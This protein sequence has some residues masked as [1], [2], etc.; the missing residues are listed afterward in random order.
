[1]TPPAATMDEYRRQI[2]QCARAL[3][4][5]HNEKVGSYLAGGFTLDH[6]KLF[7]DGNLD[8][9]YQKLLDQVE[10]LNDA[11]ENF[12]ELVVEYVKTLPL[13]AY[14]TGCSDG[15]RFLRWIGESQNP[16]AEQ[17][18]Y[19]ACQR[20][21]HVVET[22]GRSKRLSH[23]R[24]QEIWSLSSQL[25]GELDANPKL[26]VHLNPIRTWSTFQTSILLDEEASLPATVLFCACGDQIRT[27]VL[28]ISGQTLVSELETIGPCTLAE[29]ARFSAVYQRDGL[30]EFCRESAEIGLIAFG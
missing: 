13:A 18:D 26:R 14:D 30:V 9:R 21:R 5:A 8:K 11:F 2:Q 16:T 27:A 24:F 7:T 3:A 15:E 25:S 29:W 4:L 23:V 20:S 12:D 10:L 1:M 17:Q 28:E 19:I 6:L 22:V